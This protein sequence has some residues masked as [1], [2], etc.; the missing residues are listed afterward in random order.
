MAKPD[1][2]VNNLKTNH[3]IIAALC[4][5]IVFLLIQQSCNKRPNAETSVT[6]TI[7]RIPGDPYPV[8]VPIR[9][10]VPVKVEVPTEIEI[11]AKADTAEIIRNYFSR[12]AY[13]D[14]LKNDTSMLAVLKD[15]IYGN[16]I[17]S[18]EFI[19]QNRRETALITTTT[20]QH[21]LREPW[22]K[23]Y[24]GINGQY[25]P[26]SKRFGIGP[27]ATATIR[28]GG[29]ISYGYDVAGNAH[30]VGLGWKIQL[31]KSR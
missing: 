20:V 19:F 16:R 7:K 8:H 13:T 26:V 30:Q 21:K 23:L 14:T 3:L 2:M 22:L 24:L 25:S 27:T 18:R 12:A 11:P 29:L 31:K 10:P 1:H 4:G 5:I 15:T 6:T 28:P 9:I 17:I